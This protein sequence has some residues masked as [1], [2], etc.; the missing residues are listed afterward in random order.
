[1]ATPPSLTVFNSVLGGPTAYLYGAATSLALLGTACAWALDNMKMSLGDGKGPEKGAIVVR[2]FLTLG[3][4][5]AYTLISG[6]IWSFFHGAAA[7]IFPH[8]ASAALGNL[9][10]AAARR[11]QDYSFN[12]LSLVNS[13]KDAVVVFG[14]LFAFG[15]ALI[16][17][18]NLQTFQVV[19]YNTVFALGPLIIGLTPFGVPGLRTWLL[20]LVEISSWATIQAV[21]FRSIQDRLTYYLQRA[22]ELPI[23]SLEFFDIF[24][25]LAL[26]ATL[27]AIV[28]VIAG[29][30]FGMGAGAA[31]AQAPNLL[32]PQLLGSFVGGFFGSRAGKSGGG[33]GSSLPSAGDVLPKSTK[34]RRGGDV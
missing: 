5:G 30:L 21:I 15:A 26:L 7:E 34:S 25:Q 28:P 1:M 27:P 4:L 13:A 8:D 22:T 2:L 18:W 19:A 31:F 17:Y 20:I 6:S 24:S 3:A 10:G 14:S 23:T 16:G 32:T 33:G 11:F 29:R 9:M 12:A